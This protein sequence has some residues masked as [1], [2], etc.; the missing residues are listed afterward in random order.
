MAAE[1]E[2]GGHGVSTPFGAVGC[3]SIRRP[4]RKPIYDMYRQ[5]LGCDRGQR[6]RLSMRI[7]GNR[8]R[9]VHVAHALQR[10]LPSPRTREVSSALKGPSKDRHDK[11]HGTAREGKYES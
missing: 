8:N 3:G 10:P 9:K 5:A 1:T 7:Q 11:V 2:R 4:L 6:V